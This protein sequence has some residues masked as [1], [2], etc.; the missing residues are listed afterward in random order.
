MGS[1]QSTIRNDD[2][3]R[4]GKHYKQRKYHGGIQAAHNQHFYGYDSPNQVHHHGHHHHHHAYDGGHHGGHSHS[5]DGGGGGGGGG[6]S[7]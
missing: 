2:R 6:S 5:G 7:C 3:L 1:R 4:Q